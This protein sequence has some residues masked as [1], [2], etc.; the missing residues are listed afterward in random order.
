MQPKSDTEDMPLPDLKKMTSV[1]PQ[2]IVAL[3][4]SKHNT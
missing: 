1:N 3:E 2:A 4:Q